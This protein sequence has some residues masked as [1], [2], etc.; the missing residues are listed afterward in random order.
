MEA[1][2]QGRPSGRE[3][4]WPPVVGAIIVVPKDGGPRSTLVLPNK[5]RPFGMVVAGGFVYADFQ[6][7]VPVAIGLGRLPITGGAIEPLSEE[8]PRK[9]AGSGCYVIWST[10]SGLHARRR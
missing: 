8:Q 7:E 1:G 3:A 10:H 4:P 5:V 6:E 9:T 2:W